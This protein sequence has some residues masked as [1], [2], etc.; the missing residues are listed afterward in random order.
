MGSSDFVSDNWLYILYPLLEKY[1][2]IGTRGCHFADIG[3]VNR[4]VYWPGYEGRRYGESIGIG[5]IISRSVLDKLHFKPFE[6]R[7]EQSLDYSMQQRCRSVAA[8]IFTLET[9]NVKSLS[10]STDQWSNMHRFS[11]H[12]GDETGHQLLPSKRIKN[13]DEWIQQ[14]FPEALNIF[15]NEASIH[16]S[17]VGRSGFQKEI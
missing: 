5:R 9:E 1:D 12:W 7:L 10:I 4:L 14:N 6:D 11:D 17:V 8:R 13:A 2:I 3:Q 15:P 16:Q